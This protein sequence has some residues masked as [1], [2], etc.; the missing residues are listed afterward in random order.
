[1]LFLLT[2]FVLK[3]LQMNPNGSVGEASSV[4]GTAASCESSVPRRAASVAESLHVTNE[5]LRLSAPARHC[6]RLPCALVLWQPCDKPSKPGP[7]KRESDTV[8]IMLG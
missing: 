2:F 3:Y 8:M 1:M 4:P 7:V 5:E 6:L